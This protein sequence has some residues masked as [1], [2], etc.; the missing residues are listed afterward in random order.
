MTQHK[1]T[2]LITGASA[3][4]GAEFCRQLADRCEVIIAVARRGERLAQLQEELAGRVQLHP[5]EADLTTIEGV[6]RAMEALRQLGP[7][8]YLV[9][10]AGFSTYGSFPDLAIDGQRDMV[11]LHIDATITLCRA[12]IPFMRERGGGHIINVSSVGAFLPGKG[13]AVYGASKAFLN[14]FSLALQEELAGTGIEVQ[15]LCPGY[16]HT[17]FHQQIE[18]EGFNKARIPASMWMQT[19]AVVAASLAALG[20]HRVLIVPGEE[21][22]KLARAG[23]QRQLDALQEATTR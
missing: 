16:T 13:L 20:S 4:L 18:R 22:L 1:T 8:D 23:C 7:V 9:N 2:A 14:F 6:A 5:I 15:S 3:G 21:N 10:N 17:E 19:D 12:A 11:S